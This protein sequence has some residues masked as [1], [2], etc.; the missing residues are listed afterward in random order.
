M[1]EFKEDA[2]MDALKVVGDPLHVYYRK[3][4]TFHSSLE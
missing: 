1:P 2:C 4:Q 3:E